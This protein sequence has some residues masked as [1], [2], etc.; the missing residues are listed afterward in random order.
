[1]ADTYGPDDF[2]AEFAVSRETMQRL[3]AFD[4]TLLDA[5]ERMNLV[6]RSTLPTRWSRHFRDSAQL[7]ALIPAEARTLIDL[8]SGAGFP[9]LV[10]AAMFAD[11]ELGVTLVESTKKKAAF[12]TAAATAMGL[13]GVSVE[14]ARIE[15]IGRRAPDVITAR[16]LAALPKLLELATEIAGPKTVC[17]F[18]KGQDVDEE[19][20]HATK[21][22]RMSA[23][24]RESLTQSGSK[25]LILRDISRKS[26]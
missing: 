24:T 26:A 12:L 20:T 8:G 25:I 13:K 16:A 1:M 10:L 21:Y 7:A 9:G 15:T 4:R 18:P 14:A 6:A 11:R 19:L 17:I 23:E 3:D 22:W 2:A 5:A